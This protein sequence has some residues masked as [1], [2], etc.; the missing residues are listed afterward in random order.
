MST[1]PRPAADRSLK[2]VR[3]RPRSPARFVHT[4][5]QE[6]LEK[7][8]LLARQIGAAKRA[9]IKHMRFLEAAWRNKA[10]VE[11]GPLTIEDI[12]RRGGGVFVEK[13]EKP[14][15]RIAKNKAGLKR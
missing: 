4:I 14:G 5:Y 11:D 1:V 3:L 15:I 2:L 10:V 7:A 13:W 8:Q 12:L 9:Y 6:D